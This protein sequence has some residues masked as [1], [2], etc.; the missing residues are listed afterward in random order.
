MI[1]YKHLKITDLAPLLVYWPRYTQFNTD[2]NDIRCTVNLSLCRTNFGIHTHP[3]TT[4]TRT[5]TT[6]TTMTNYEIIAHTRIEI[7]LIVI[8]VAG[9]KKCTVLY[10]QIKCSIDYA[11]KIVIHKRALVSIVRYIYI[12]I[13]YIERNVLGVNKKFQKGKKATTWRRRRKAACKCSSRW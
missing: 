1:G 13:Y 11:G 5:T 2:K 4:K 9:V 8:Y 6:T 7:L 12:S 10:G 3:T